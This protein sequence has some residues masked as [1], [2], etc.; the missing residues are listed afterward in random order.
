MNLKR[1]FLATE[2]AS[3]RMAGAENRMITGYAAVFYNGDPGTEYDIYGD[4]YLF[5]RIMPGAFDRAIAEDDVRALENH[6][7][8][9]VLGRTKAGTLRLFADSIGLRYEIDSPDTSV[10]RDLMTNIGLGNIDGSSFSFIMTDNNEIRMENGKRILEVTGVRLFDVG[11]V[12]F[13]AY[14]SAS[15]GVR[16]VE[17]VDINLRSELE[18]Q[19]KERIAAL[20]RDR[21]RR[22]RMVRT[23]S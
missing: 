6:D 15:S 20:V 16:S 19:E 23:F 17:S 13:P 21:E 2:T 5:E 22:V 10:S 3:I 14:A 9:R 8:N 11:P 7:K 1:R 12:T 18:A 4:G